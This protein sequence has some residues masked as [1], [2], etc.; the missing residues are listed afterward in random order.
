MRRLAALVVTLALTSCEGRPGGLTGVTPLNLPATKLTSL[1]QPTDEAAGS[2][3]TPVIQVAVQNGS[4][5][6]VT[7]STASISVVI[8]PNSGTAGA[9]LTGTT[10]NNPTSGGIAVFS[11]LRINLAGTGYTL[12]FSAPGLAPAVS[13]TFTIQ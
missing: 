1:S 2:P 13:N 8:T 9:I 7:N 4:N 5:Q 12:T 3:L 11:D 6:T 10:I